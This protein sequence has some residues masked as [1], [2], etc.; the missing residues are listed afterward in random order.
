MS[1][2]VIGLTPNCYLRVRP[3]AG[4]TT[5]GAADRAREA[6]RDRLRAER[7]GR[8]LG[9][10]RA[11]CAGAGGSVSDPANSPSTVGPDPLTQRRLR[12]CAAGRRERD[13]DLRAERPGGVLRDRCAAAP[14]AEGERRRRAHLRARDGGPRAPR[15][16]ARGPCGRLA[17]TRQR[18]I[19]RARRAAPTPRATSDPT[20]RA[21]C[22]RSQIAAAPVAARPAPLASHRPGRTWAGTSAPRVRASRPS[23]SLSPSPEA[24]AARRSAAA[25]SPEPPPRP[26]ATGTCLTMLSCSGGGIPTGGGAETRRARGGE[27]LLGRALHPGAQHLIAR[28]SRGAPRAG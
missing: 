9:R 27:V 12:A 23:N 16:P 18:S 22:A 4:A 6:R 26:A 24:A 17:R 8:A 21:V 7:R 15:A 19:A 1:V 14:R 10:A 20:L 11:A 3:I 25:A 5:P 28:T 13:V 2:L